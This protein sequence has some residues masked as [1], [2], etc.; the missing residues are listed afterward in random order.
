MVFFAIG[1][2]VN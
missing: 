2:L 1:F